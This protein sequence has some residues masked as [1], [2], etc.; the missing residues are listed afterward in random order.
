M[1][2]ARLS[3]LSPDLLEELATYLPVRSI[4]RLQQ[5]S[6]LFYMLGKEIMDSQAAWVADAGPLQG[7]VS[8]LKEQLTAVPSVG[9]LYIHRWPFETR[10]LDS[11]PPGICLIG[12]TVPSSV[13]A[14]KVSLKHA[15]DIFLSSAL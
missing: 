11:L 7:V 9:V 15:S 4:T 1:E 5:A 10:L 3:S 12:G 14:T 8:N 13:L 2:G 6:R